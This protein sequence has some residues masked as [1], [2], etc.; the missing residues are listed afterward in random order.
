M[1]KKRL[2][3]IIVA[4]GIVVLTIA[5]YMIGWNI[6]KYYRLQSSLQDVYFMEYGDG[7]TIYK[8]DVS[9][10]KTVTVAELE[11]GRYS[12]CKINRTENYIIGEFW[13]YKEDTTVLLRYNLSD[14]TAEEITGKEAEIMEERIK[15]AES[16][17]P[18]RS[19]LPEE[20]RKIVW[21]MFIGW[22]ADGEMAVFY[23]GNQEKIYLYNADTE[24]CE[25]I[26]TAG[27]NQT[28]GP[29]LGLDASGKYLFYENN[30]NYLFDTADVKI[31]IY[32]IQTGMRTKIYERKYT[33]HSYNF[34]QEMD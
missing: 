34:V 7:T 4:M 32:D 8:Y 12:D 5:L 19:S 18:E 16:K 17:L 14:D 11:G 28:F 1:K 6:V 9:R 30:F 13:R 33:Q 23:D 31:I 20:V 21:N 26:L 3:M 22:S 27:W 2:K 25:C 29:V 24:T 10:R 15:E